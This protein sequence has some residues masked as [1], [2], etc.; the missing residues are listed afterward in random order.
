[1]TIS[2]FSPDLLN[3]FTDL[4][5]FFSGEE[6]IQAIAESETV[7]PSNDPPTLYYNRWQIAWIYITTP[8]MGIFVLF[9]ETIAC[10]LF[11]LGAVGTS[12]VFTLLAKHSLYDW[13]ILENQNIYQDR[14]L[15]PSRNC[16]DLW[17]TDVY[18]TPPIHESMI[19]DKKVRKMIF[20]K[21]IV[22]IDS[23]AKQLKDDVMDG[24]KKIHFLNF[25]SSDGLCRG[26]SSWWMFLFLSTKHLLK[27]PYEHVKAVS[28]I[29]E[30]GAPRK[31]ALLHTLA[32]DAEALLLN[33]ETTDV[34]KTDYKHIHKDAT[35]T[36]DDLKKI[37]PGEYALGFR[38]HRINYVK[39]RDDLGFIWDP[40]MGPLPLEGEDHFE[41]LL[42]KMRLYS[43]P[44]KDDEVYFQRCALKDF[45][46]PKK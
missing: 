43:T 42:D 30:K 26:M 32:G 27:D 3:N 44:D 16:H 25:Y 24:I 7:D 37:P 45:L 1:M 31:A 41:N 40:N 5:A 23:H 38:T 33:M 35:K 9:C 11:H 2:A 10:L 28:K 19:V 4:K 22:K 17:T 34:F 20:Y 39:Y 6:E 18:T 8:F 36:L 12:R 13:K 46:N 15:V 29:F 14:F 21:A